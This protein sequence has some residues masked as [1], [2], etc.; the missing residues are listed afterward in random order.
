MSSYF[1]ICNVYLCFVAVCAG[2]CRYNSLYLY[3]ELFSSRNTFLPF[4][5]W[6]LCGGWR[7]LWAYFYDFLGSFQELDCC[8]ILVILDTSIATNSRVYN[9]GRGTWGR[10]GSA[11]NYS[12]SLEIPLSLRAGLRKR[13]LFWRTQELQ[14]L[15]RQVCL[16]LKRSC[17]HCS[18]IWIGYKTY[19]YIAFKGNRI[20]LDYWIIIFLP[21]FDDQ[22]DYLECCFWTWQQTGRL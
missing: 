11:V 4:I 18:L 13:T 1:D 12:G 17:I 14:A 19:K 5:F 15:F 3:L 2:M 9:P 7:V 16:H 21:P 20:L 8:Y 6:F 10:C 22:T